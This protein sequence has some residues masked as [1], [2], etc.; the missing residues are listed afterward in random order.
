MYF[1][2]WRK[3]NK[4][5]KDKKAAAAGTAAVHLDQT[6]PYGQGSHP[7]SGQNGRGTGYNGGYDRLDEEKEERVALASSPNG[8]R[9]D[10]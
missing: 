5:R 4:K 6:G 9:N 1:Q 2:G 7:G 3:R 8:A 10:H